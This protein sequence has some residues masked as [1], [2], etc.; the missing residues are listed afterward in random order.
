MNAQRLALIFS[1]VWPEPNSSAAGVRQMQ[2]IRY[3]LRQGYRVALSSPSKL[4]SAGD[5]GF[6]E[7]PEGVEVLPLPL[8]ESN[9]DGQ[10]LSETF[11]KLNP[12]IVMFDRFILEEQFGHWIYECCPNARVMLETQDL[13]FVRRARESVKDQYLAKD[14]A[15]EF[16]QTSEV[17]DTALREVASI[18]RVD[19]TFVVSSFEERLLTDQFEVPPSRVTWIPMVADSVLAGE[20]PAAGTTKPFKDRSGFC[21]VGNFRHQPNIDGLRWFKGEIWP[22]LRIRFPSAQIHVY[23]AYP[24]E[25]VMSWNKPGDGFHV[26]GHADRLSTVF[27][28]A[29]VNVAPLRFGAGV[30]GKILEAI[31]FQIP[32]VTTKVGVEGILP[33]GATAQDAFPGIEA[34]TNQIFAEAC[35]AIH[36]DETLWTKMQR[37]TLDL[38][39]LYSL[40]FAEKKMELAFKKLKPSF[41][42]KVMRHELFNSHKYFARW[43]EAKNKK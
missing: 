3:F 6:V 33:L 32:T 5:W 20:A 29:R 38:A 24:S 26:H 13:H 28:S 25:E 8:N 1:T 12:E 30:K 15:P 17:I 14:Y 19:H 36:E 18:H 39:T 16:Y 21:W 43:I 31:A 27:E 35:L 4:K 34:N 10:H 9:V 37:R 40:D 7:Y 22:R 11:K 23:G 42:S 2:W 41:T